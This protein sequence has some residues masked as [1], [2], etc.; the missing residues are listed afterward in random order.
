MK[1]KRVSRIPNAIVKVEIVDHLSQDEID[2]REKTLARLILLAAERRLRKRQ[3][4]ERN[5]LLS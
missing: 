5:I 2:Q 4:V 3:S 1:E